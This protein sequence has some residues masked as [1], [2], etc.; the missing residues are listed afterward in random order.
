MTATGVG[1][2]SAVAHVS[3]RWS[4]LRSYLGPVISGVCFIHCIGL[5]VLAPILP[6]AVA[7]LAGTTWLEWGLW[8]VSVAGTGVSLRRHRARP[9]ALLAWVLAAMI[10]ALGLATEADRL[11]QIS[12]GTSVAIQLALVARRW[13]T[14]NS[15][16]S[17]D[18]CKACDHERNHE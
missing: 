17:L 16:C 10:G 13:G 1:V 5:V 2:E 15:A 14:A 4:G 8:L 9:R 11:V 18:D 3:G 7:L 6:G 12:L